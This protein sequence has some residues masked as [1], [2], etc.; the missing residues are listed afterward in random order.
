MLEEYASTD[1]SKEKP[2][3][4]SWRCHDNDK[5]EAVCENGMKIEEITELF[6]D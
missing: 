2:L 6:N 3:F 4:V 5:Y 1:G